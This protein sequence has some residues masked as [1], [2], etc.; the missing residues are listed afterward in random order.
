MS[1]CWTTTYGLPIDALRRWIV[2]EHAPA[3]A[4]SSGPS[5]TFLD[6]RQGR[7]FDTEQSP[8]LLQHSGSRAVVPAVGSAV[9]TAGRLMIGSPAAGN[10]VTA[11]ACQGHRRQNRAESRLYERKKRGQAALAMLYFPDDEADQPE[12]P[13]AVG[14][15]PDRTDPVA[16]ASRPPSWSRSLMAAHSLRAIRRWSS[17]AARPVAP[18]IDLTAP[19]RSMLR[20]RADVAGKSVSVQEP[21]RRERRQLIDPHRHVDRE[22]A[23]ECDCPGCFLRVP[24][25]PMQHNAGRPALLDQVEDTASQSSRMDRGD[26]TLRGGGS[27]EGRQH[28]L[29]V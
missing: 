7:R 29:L 15:G 14:S 27:Q 5:S 6:D 12:R 16:R 20:S 9:A 3:E 13:I 22:V 28:Q 23:A 4:V 19:G 8:R 18:P 24:G 17:Q 26:D 1:D 11:T 25:P 10:A 21:L 2:F